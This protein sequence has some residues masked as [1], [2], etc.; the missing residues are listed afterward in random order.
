MISLSL[1]GKIAPFLAMDVMR[2]ARVRSRAG[3]AIC[4]M[5]VGQP[6]TPAPQLVRERAKQLLDE[7]LIGY[8][9]AL[10]IPALRERIAQHYQEIYEAKIDPEQVVITTG[11]SAGF[12]LAFLATLDAGDKVAIA[13]PGYPCYREILKALDLEPVFL[14]LG[15]DNGWMPTKS[16][17]LQAIEQHNIKALLVASPANPT[18]VVLDDELICEIGAMAA[19]KGVWFL[20]DEIYHGLVYDRQVGTAANLNDVTIVLNSFSKYYSMTGWR[21]GWMVVPKSVVRRLE[22]LNQHLFISAPALS[23]LA[24]ICAFDTIDELE[25]IKAGYQANREVLVN[26]LS[27]AGIGPIAPPDGAFYVYADVSAFTNDSLEFAKFLLRTY[28]IAVCPGVDFDETMGRTMIRFSY[29]GTNSEI[30]EAVKRL[31]EKPL[32]GRS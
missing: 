32:S 26:G 23:Q 5:E 27:D 1:R 24:A 21:I 12:V 3:E 16:N 11:S 2:E 6:G 17:I 28:G 10:G 25:A 4:H 29:A 18:G 7:D 15:F 22:K 31:K 20:V 9:E 19:E 13:Q 8:T 14:P 30:V